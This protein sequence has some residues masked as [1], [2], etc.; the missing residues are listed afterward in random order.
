MNKTKAFIHICNEEWDDFTAEITVNANDARCAC[1][2]S[3]VAL[4]D[5]SSILNH[6]QDKIV[7]R[8]DYDLPEKSKT[9]AVDFS[10]FQDLHF[11]LNL[12]VDVLFKLN[13]TLYAEIYVYDLTGN[14]CH[15]RCIQVS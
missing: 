10:L 12:N 15:K 9:K 14:L 4:Q 5:L 3:K 1:G 6:V 2:S 7:K 13:Q 11:P 8:N